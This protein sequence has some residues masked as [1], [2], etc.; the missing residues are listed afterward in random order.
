M[1]ESPLTP[2]NKLAGPPAAASCT[3]LICQIRLAGPVTISL[4]ALMKRGADYVAWSLHFAL[5]LVVGAVAGWF[6]VARV[7][8]I[9]GSLRLSEANLWLWLLGAGL[10]GGGLAS[11]FGDRLWI[12]LSYRIIPPDEPA[13]DETSRAASVMVGIGGGVVAIAALL[14]HCSVF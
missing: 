8:R 9:Y 7:E 4:S 2:A 1:S 11:R 5:G 10:I 6:I 13:H 14:R 12:G 3:H